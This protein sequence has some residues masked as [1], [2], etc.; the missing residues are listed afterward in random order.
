MENSTFKGKEKSNLKMKLL[1]FLILILVL[2]FGI[3][4]NYSLNA[5]HKELF[6]QELVQFVA[7]QHNPLFSGTGG[8]TWD[9]QIRERGYIIKEDSLYHL[10]YTGYDSND[11]T[12]LLGYA[13]STD[14][15]NFNRHFQNPI[16]HSSWVEDMCVVKKADTYY[17]FAEGKGDSAHLLT[18]KDKINWE[19]KGSLDIRQT[20]GKPI[21]SG[22]FGTP[23]VLLENGLWY[24]FYER[25]DLG[26][27]LATSKD[28]SFW[29]NVQ[30]EPV[31]K[32]GPESYDQFAVA[33]DQI[34]Q[35]KGLYY[36]YYHAS[37]FKD[38]HE[39]STNVAVS[40]DL[41]HWKKYPNNP[42]IGNNLSSGILLKDGE[43]FRLYTMHERINLFFSTSVS[44]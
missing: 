29:T 34:I 3:E 44:K 23:T 12:R 6:P 42:I 37:A 35:Y 18:S 10:W 17:M 43:G 25:D 41:I 15:I 40:S 22:S 16:H 14:G 2:N 36:G 20:N 31:L 24:L 32:M 19:E 26:I 4:C 21:S 28:L 38:W 1:T 13:T 5:S 30:D 27:W 11:G 9:K 7:Y 39:W 33:M 8:A